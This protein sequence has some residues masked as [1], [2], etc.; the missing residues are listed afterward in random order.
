MS[1]VILL[2]LAPIFFVMV[3]GYGAGRLHRIDN[4]HVA[5]LN[6]LVM[7]FSLP[8]ALFMATA[9]TPRAEMI[10][11][12]PF[13]A[14]LCVAML[15]PY[16]L[17]FYCR[18]KIQGLPS[19]EAAVEALSVSLPNYAAA[20]LPLMVAILGPKEAVHVAVAIAAGCIF[21]SP[22]T[23]VILELSAANGQASAES[24]RARLWRALRHAL[25]KP[26][27]LAPIAGL[28]LSISGLEPGD[29]VRASLR[30]IGQAAGGVALFLTGLILSAQP[31]RLDRK[32]VAATTVAN[33]IQPLFV[34]AIVYVFAVPLNIAKP[35]I[36]LAALPSGF[37]GILFGVNY[38]VVPAEAGS[39]I[40][41]STAVSVVTLA[42]AIAV[43]YPQ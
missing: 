24:T 38:K 1:H 32:V 23:L 27:L 6:S 8:A 39:I 35:A 22:I 31:F 18:N 20:G 9:S 33:V 10:E 29:V 12:G 30:L 2:A 16:L 4:H 41:A 13:F 21:T 36:L 25:G 5:G 26:I 15:I 19:G 28:I 17:W 43:L 11:Q 40:I 34:A 3:L 37:F 7:E 14:I 42:I